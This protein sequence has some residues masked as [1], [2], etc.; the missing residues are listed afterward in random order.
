[1]RWP[2]TPRRSSREPDEV[3]RSVGGCCLIGVLFIDDPCAAD[4][5]EESHC[6]D[7]V[8]VDRVEPDPAP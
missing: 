4:A 3:R 5:C 2:L 6:V 7:S 8:P 1:M